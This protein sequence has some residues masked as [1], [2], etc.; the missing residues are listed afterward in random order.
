ML[1][2]RRRLLGEDVDGLEGDE[3]ALEHLVED[4]E[5]LGDFFGAVDDLDA[6]GEVLGEAE[7]VGS[8]DSGV[9]AEAHDAEGGGGSG[10]AELAAALDDG[11]G[12]VGAVIGV[13]ASEV[14]GEALGFEIEGHGGLLREG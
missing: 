6:F 13:G 3:A 9:L 1:R 8:V 5:D 12:E 7:E 14:D 4:G 2:L 10:E 11:G